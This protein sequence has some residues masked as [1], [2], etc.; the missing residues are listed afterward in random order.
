M[1]ALL[2]DMHNMG[3]RCGALYLYFKHPL[4]NSAAAATLIDVGCEVISVNGD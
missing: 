4:K 1:L 3:F 2:L